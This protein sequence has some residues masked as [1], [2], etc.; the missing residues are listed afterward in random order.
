M[1]H[2]LDV[3]TEL[4]PVV[5]LILHLHRLHHETP[6]QASSQLLNGALGPEGM[7]QA[8]MAPRLIRSSR[9]SLA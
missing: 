1:S 2:L 4:L 6:A 9:D 7:R 3:L 5:V 8:A